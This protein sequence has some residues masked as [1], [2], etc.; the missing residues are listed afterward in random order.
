MQT[1]PVAAQDADIVRHFRRLSRATDWRRAGTISMQFQ[2][3]HPQGMVI[4]G[5]HIFFSSVEVTVP[6]ERFGLVVDG[7]DR[8][9]G[10]G[11]AHLFKADREG[12]LIARVMLGEGSVYHPGG[13][14]FDGDFIWVPVAEY[15]P[16]SRSI[17][18]RV[19]PATMEAT[20]VFRFPDHI[21]GVVHDTTSKTLHG[22]SWGSRFF[23]AWEL[24][25][26]L[27]LAVST[28]DPAGLRTPNGS[29][30]VDYQDCHYVPERYMLCGGVSSY[31]VSAQGDSVGVDFALGGIDLIDLRLQ[32][33]VHQ[34]P[35]TRRVEPDLVMSKNP[36]FVELRDDHLRFYFMPE[37]NMST[38]YIFDAYRE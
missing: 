23:Y 15:R 34:V 7:Y 33:A 27:E 29:H 6:T 16:N 11:V 18:Y 2:T 36:F 19:N 35:I 31:S 22:V 25:D 28:L 32:R 5:E 9:A 20:E 13:I 10:E 8:T 38:V 21:G 1:L 14:D 3:Y 30:Y 26:E 17:I 37:D 24:N 12:N 4:V